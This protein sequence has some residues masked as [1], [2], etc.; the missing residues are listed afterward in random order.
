[1]KIVSETFEEKIKIHILRSIAFSESRAVYEIMWKN[2]GEPQ[3]TQY[4]AEKM[5]F[6]CRTAKARMRTHTHNI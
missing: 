5:Q 3:M 2:I 1:M 4:G 6:A